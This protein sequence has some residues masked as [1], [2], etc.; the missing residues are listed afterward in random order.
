MKNS[1]PNSVINETINRISLKR[2]AQP[3]EIADLVLFL[4][5]DSSKYITGQTIRVDGGMQ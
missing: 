3:S 2:I 4:V 5:S 1:H